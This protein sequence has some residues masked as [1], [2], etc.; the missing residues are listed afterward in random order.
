METTQTKIQM[1]N[2]F[3]VH[4]EKKTVNLDGILYLAKMSFK[5]KVEIKN[6]QT[7]KSC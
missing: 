4:K 2:I 1:S 7:D 3:K 6:F 5:N